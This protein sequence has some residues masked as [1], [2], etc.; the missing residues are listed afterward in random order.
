LWLRDRALGASAA[1]FQHLEYAGR[2]LG[3][4]LD[5]RSGWPAEGLASAMVIA[6]TAA[7]VDALA[8]AFF[9]LG[10]DNARAYCDSHPEIGA[11]LLPQ[12]AD[13]P[14][15]LGLGAE[16]LELAPTTPD[17]PPSA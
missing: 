4:I 12:D 11:V 3:H 8:T 16:A 17:V 9:I 15:V 1:S 5:P 2:K 7:V 10:N 6:P 13:R 14:V